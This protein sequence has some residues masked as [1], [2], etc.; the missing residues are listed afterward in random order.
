[1]NDGLRQLGERISQIMQQ[2]PYNLSLGGDWSNLGLDF[3]SFM[4]SKD[5][6]VGGGTEDRH[7]PMSVEGIPSPKTER[8]IPKMSVH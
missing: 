3:G 8:Q 1:M 5:V 4:G 6:K 2:S 7:T